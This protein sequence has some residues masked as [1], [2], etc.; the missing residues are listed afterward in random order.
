MAE[1]PF[2]PKRAQDPDGLE[3]SNAPPGLDGILK[4]VAQNQPP[5]QPPQAPAAPVPAAP[6]PP[7]APQMPMSAAPPSRLQGLIDQLPVTYDAVQLPSMGKF[8]NNEVL[9]KGV[10]HIRRMTGAE[11]EVLATPRLVKKNEAIDEIFRKCLQE[12]IETE[13]LLTIDR[14][15]LLIYLR[16]ISY[17]TSYEVEVK[18]PSCDARFETEIELLALDKED[19]PNDFTTSNLRDTLP[20]TG[21]NFRYRLSTGKDDALVGLHREKRVERFSNQT[22]D[23]TLSF[24]SALLLEEIEGVT[25]T[26]DLQEL[27]KRLPIGDVSYLRNTINDPPFGVDTNVEI[28]CPVCTEVFKMDL[29]LEASFFFPRSKRRDQMK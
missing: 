11:E 15:Y 6:T 7:P 29:P 5:A 28:V 21:W 26:R 3:I 17:S 19:C 16:G 23:D 4:Q 9:Q 20:E 14:T 18:C 12:N 27:L 22:T 13:S 10:L 1:E 25:D 24:R 2:R 8:Y